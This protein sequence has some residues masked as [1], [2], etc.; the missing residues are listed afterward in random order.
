MPG[1]TETNL[2]ELS[3]PALQGS[4]KFV[5]SGIFSGAAGAAA[6][7]AGTSGRRC[8]GSG[9]GKA[10]ISAG[11]QRRGGPGPALA[12]GPRNL[13]PR[14]RGGRA[15][16]EPRPGSGAAGFSGSADLP[17]PSSSKGPGAPQK[18][19]IAGGRPAQRARAPGCPRQPQPPPGAHLPDLGQTRVAVPGRRPA[20][21]ARPRCG[22]ARGATAGGR[23]ADPLRAGHGGAGM[24]LRGG[25]A[26]RGGPF[27]APARARRAAAWGT[28]PRTSR[29]LSAPLCAPR[30]QAGR[31]PRRKGAPRLR[32]EVLLQRA[33]GPAQ[34][35]AR[36]GGSA[37]R[38]C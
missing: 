12:R 14:R 35:P 31:P 32:G 5:F 8:A 20:S 36:L 9:A 34:L 37:P 26:G 29:A 6:P 3:F 22:D 10:G 30:G 38:Y 27:L 17:Q 15:E 18:A 33:L 19:R 21:A 28:G 23:R 25:G 11:A 16:A 2:C 13:R 1:L 24:R 7:P 4:D